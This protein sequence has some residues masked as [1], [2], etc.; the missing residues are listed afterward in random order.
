MI[1]A[2]D[3]LM[4]EAKRSAKGTTF[5]KELGPKPVVSEPPALRRP[6]LKGR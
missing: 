4:Y 6:A 5:Y 3:T 1:A 2:A